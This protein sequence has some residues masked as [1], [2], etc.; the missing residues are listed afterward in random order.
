MDRLRS[1]KLNK[2]YKRRPQTEISHFNIIGR[3]MKDLA[4][5]LQD[6]TFARDEDCGE[7]PAREPELHPVRR[8]RR[9]FKAQLRFSKILFLVN[10]IN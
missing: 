2:A 3:F 9:Q 4:E 1:D 10:N 6:M 5:N 8:S 7:G